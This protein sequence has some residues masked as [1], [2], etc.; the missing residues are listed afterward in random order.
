VSIGDYCTV[1]GAVFATNGRVVIDDFAFVA[2]EVV[3]ADD[4]SVTP[5]PQRPVDDVTVAIGEN[6]WIGARVV[7]LRGA[8]IGRD[9]VVGAGT[10][11][12][13]V[14]PDGV[15]VAGDPY[16]VIGSAGVVRSAA[17]AVGSVR[18]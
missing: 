13:G 11:V 12:D 15:I 10:I 14:V 8:R 7:L 6:A 16:R 4:H 9:A 2:H 17:R 3:I 5:G 1:V 18:E